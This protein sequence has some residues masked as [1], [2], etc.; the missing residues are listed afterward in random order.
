MLEVQRFHVW[1]KWT[2]NFF[3]AGVKLLPATN[4]VILLL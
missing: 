3:A 4:I 2:Y 1:L